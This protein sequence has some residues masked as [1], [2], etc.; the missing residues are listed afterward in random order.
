[1][2]TQRNLTTIEEPMAEEAPEEEI[3]GTVLVEEKPRSSIF[4]LLLLVSIIF[5]LIGIYL[6]GYELNTFYG[7][8]FGGL[9]SAPE[10][11]KEEIDLTVEPG[12]QMRPPEPPGTPETDEKHSAPEKDIEKG[13]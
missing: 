2:V 4:T 12:R 7:V 3:G 9:F 1:M 13:G 11:A 5:A 6:V 8:E 10:E